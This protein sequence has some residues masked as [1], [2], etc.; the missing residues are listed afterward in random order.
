MTNDK[1]IIWIG[2][3]QKELRRFPKEARRKTGYQLHKVQLGKEPSD[4]RPMPT[5]GKGVKEIRIRTGDAYRVFY[6]AKFE[7]AVYVLHAFEK[8][9]QK[10]SKRDIQLGRQR[11]QKMLRERQERGYS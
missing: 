6:V 7:E 11:Y 4:T 8:K 5:I 9:T 2:T 10:T 3:S 1:S